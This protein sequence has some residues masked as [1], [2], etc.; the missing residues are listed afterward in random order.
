MIGSFFSLILRGV[1]L[2]SALI[3]FASLTLLAL[4]LLVLWLLR[5]LWARL[6][7]RP[8]RPWTFQF[9]R[10][11][12]WQDFRPGAGLMSATPASDRD[13][14]DVEIKEVREINK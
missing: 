4:L 5:A 12:A 6:T 14:I 1:F 3:F 13:V 11:A 9:R 2:L 10:Y 8:V 7:G